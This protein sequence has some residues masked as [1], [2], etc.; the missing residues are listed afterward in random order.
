MHSERVFCNG[1]WRNDKLHGKG[2]LE[3]VGVFIYEGELKEGR[4]EGKGRQFML[5]A[6][7]KEVYEVYSGLF[8]A[9]QREGVGKSIKMCGYLYNGEWKGNKPHGSGLERRPACCVEQRWEWEAGIEE[10]ELQKKSNKR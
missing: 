7:N 6:D 1:E 9:D 3:L 8:K 2:R 10:I 4:I 5:R